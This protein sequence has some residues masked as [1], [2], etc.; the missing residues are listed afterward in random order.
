MQI[1]QINE[2]KSKAQH[3]LIT[4]KVHR[5]NVKCFKRM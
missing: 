1:D 5:L 3:G 2:S 4:T